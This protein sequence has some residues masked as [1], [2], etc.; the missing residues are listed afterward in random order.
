MIE[1]SAHRLS[2]PEAT[3]RNWATQMDMDTGLETQGEY[4]HSTYSPPPAPLT[5][6]VVQAKHSD[7]SNPTVYFALAKV[8]SDIKSILT[9]VTKA[10]YDS[11]HNHHT[12]KTLLAPS[13]WLVHTLSTLH[14]P[15]RLHGVLMESMRTPWRFSNP[16][17][18]VHEDSMWSP[19][20]LC[21]LYVDSPWTLHGHLR[22]QCNLKVI[23]FMEKIMCHERDSN[24]GPLQGEDR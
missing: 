20:S 22:S 2:T 17:C 23:N 7:F 5:Q 15:T 3:E 18:R 13:D 16:P 9:V 4:M 8:K 14:S 1:P 11:G 19:W 24:M 21:G 12:G 10:F 6:G